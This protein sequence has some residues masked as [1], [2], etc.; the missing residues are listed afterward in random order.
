M[1][2]F[3]TDIIYSL[4]MCVKGLTTRYGVEGSNPSKSFNILFTQKYL[5]QS[6]QWLLVF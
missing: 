1:F 4:M 5:T 6:H 2:Y 3:T